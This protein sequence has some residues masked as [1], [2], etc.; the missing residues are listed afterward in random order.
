M[1]TKN[2]NISTTNTL[3]STTMGTPRHKPRA[4]LRD[5]SSSLVLKEGTGR[6]PSQAP[7]SD[8]ATDN[9]R[10]FVLASEADNQKS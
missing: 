10:A 3:C 2:I 8:V 4:I 9:K 6:A 7:D 5:S 1:S